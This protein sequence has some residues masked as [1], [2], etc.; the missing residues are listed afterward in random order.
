MKKTLTLMALCALFTSCNSGE[1]ITQLKK[2]N[3]ELQTKVAEL[4]KE[5]EIKAKLPAGMMNMIANDTDLVDTTWVSTY[6]QTWSN[7]YSRQFGGTLGFLVSMNDLYY[8]LQ[9]TPYTPQEL[10]FYLG[11]NQGGDSLKL[12]WQPAYANPRFGT[13]ASDTPYIAEYFV[14]NTNPPQIF[15]RTDPCP[16]CLISNMMGNISYLKAPIP[17]GSAVKRKMIKDKNNK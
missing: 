14:S 12:F 3:S 11:V 8:T 5:L 4:K 15:D 17:P 7:F 2:E 13:G 9:N 1:D 6:M 16:T 10:I